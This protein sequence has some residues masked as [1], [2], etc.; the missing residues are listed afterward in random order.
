MHSLFQASKKPLRT[1]I[2]LSEWVVRVFIGFIHQ[3][4][5]DPGFIRILPGEENRGTKCLVVA[6]FLFFEKGHYYLAQTGLKLSDLASPAQVL[7]LH[8]CATLLAS[9]R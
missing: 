4:T 3:K 6:F 8:T 2:W 5:G 7:G 9:F 1:H